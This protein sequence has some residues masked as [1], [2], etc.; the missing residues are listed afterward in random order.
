MNDLINISTKALIE[1]LKSR[2]G[3]Q[4]FKSQLYNGYNVDIKVMDAIK[5]YHEGQSIYCVLK[6]G[7]YIYKPCIR[8]KCV[9]KLDGYTLDDDWDQVMTTDELLHGTWYIGEPNE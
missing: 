7:K 2:E 8:H 9:N 6:G 1:E 4:A 3:V 5:A